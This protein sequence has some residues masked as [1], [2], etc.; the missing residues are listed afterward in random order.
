[1]KIR[2][3]IIDD[4]E[5]ARKLL[6]NYIQRIPQLELVAA[7]SNPVAAMPILQKETIDLIFLDIQMPELSGTEFLRSLPQK[8]LTIFTT[9][10]PE[11]AL[12]SYELEAVDYLVKPFSFE[13]FFQAVNKTN[14]FLSKRASDKDFILVKSEHKI[15]KITFDDIFY[16]QSMSEYVAYYT[17]DG[18][19]LSLYA[20]KKLETELPEDLFIRSHK[21]YIVAIKKV[22]TLEGNLMHLVNGEK[23]PIGQNYKEGVMARIFDS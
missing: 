22:K 15:Y 10:Y 18:R 13:R 7:C 20:L 8:P 19:I 17:K 12:E 21:S 3:L 16:I 4:E 1:M 2:C 23:V 6:E 5:L 14:K 11:Y 9:A